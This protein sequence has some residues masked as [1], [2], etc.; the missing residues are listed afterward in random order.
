MADIKKLYASGISQIKHVWN[1]SADFTFLMSYAKA[2]FIANII[3]LF[4]NLFAGGSIGFIIV[5]I[6][7]SLFMPMQLN[8]NVLLTIFIFGIVFLTIGMTFRIITRRITEQ[9][10][11]QRT[12]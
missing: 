12:D 4:L 7:C 6:I 9:Y 11:Q 5:L 8:A 2:I 3:A 1:E 10:K